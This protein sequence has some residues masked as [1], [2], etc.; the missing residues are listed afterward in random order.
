MSAP[1]YYR[2]GSFAALVLATLVVGALLGAS[3]L[4]TFTDDGQRAVGG[5]VYTPPASIDNTGQTDVTDALNQWIAADTADGTAG[6]P[7]VIQLNGTYRVEYGLMIG[8]QRPQCRTARLAGVRAQSRRARP[9]ECDPAADRP[10]PYRV[11]GTVVQP[12]KR[13]GVPLITIAGETDVTVEGGDLLSTDTA[14]TYSSVRALGRR[15]DQQWGVE[16]LARRNG[17]R[18]GVGRLRRHRR[19][20]PGRRTS[21]STAAISSATGAKA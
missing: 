21:S 18:A 5:V 9:H 20:D 12:R 14:G 4:A 13:W 10:T 15:Q 8:E 2:R 3:M 7:S 11:N 17:H 6:D 19:S 1:M 16:C